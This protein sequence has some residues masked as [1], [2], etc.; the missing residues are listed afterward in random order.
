ML[1]LILFQSAVL[2]CL[3]AAVILWRIQFSAR[4]REIQTC[5]AWSLG[6]EQRLQSAILRLQMEL[7]EWKEKE[8][9][10][11]QRADPPSLLPT[12]GSA[13]TGGAPPVLTVAKRSQAL[14][15]IRLGEK[16]EAVS[17]KL[18][19]PDS[20]IRLLIKVQQL[21]QPPSATS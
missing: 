12:P 10:T 13:P 14:R 8:K 16:P 5:A 2:A 1:I 11:P 4:L 15:M 3:I 17:A 7:D 6:S 19:I 21:I 20:H 18:G 9:D